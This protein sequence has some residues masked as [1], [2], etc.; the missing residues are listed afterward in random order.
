MDKF[1]DMEELSKIT[2]F[3]TGIFVSHVNL[4]V[5]MSY[6]NVQYKYLFS[7]TYG[8]LSIWKSNRLVL[9]VPLEGHQNK[10]RFSS[11]MLYNLLPKVHRDPLLPLGNIHFHTCPVGTH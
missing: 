2:F 1:P 7:K 9:L 3:K 6:G 11:Q 4:R 5:L 10:L 8:S